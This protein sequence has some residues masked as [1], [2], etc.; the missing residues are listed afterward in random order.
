M[1]ADGPL[2]GRVAADRGWLL[3]HRLII[4]L[5]IQAIRRDPTESVWTDEASNLSRPDRSGSD[6]IDVEHQAT[7]LAVGVRIPRAARQRCR[8]AAIKQEKLDRA[9]LA[10]AVLGHL[11]ASILQFAR[12]PADP[13]GDSL[14]EW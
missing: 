12:R 3:S 14:I 9:D 10:V 7:D 4:R 2:V 5:I 8:S 6:Q 1:F 13:Q 11:V